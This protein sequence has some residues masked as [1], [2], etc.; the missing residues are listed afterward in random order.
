M[1]PQPPQL[2][3]LLEG[4]VVPGMQGH[5]K[6]VPAVLTQRP[7]QQLVPDAHCE[8]SAQPQAP[9]TQDVPLAQTVP[10]AP[11]CAASFSAVSQ[12]FSV[13]ASQSAKPSSHMPSLQ[14]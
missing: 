6:H 9:L 13:F 1:L 12:P 2:S 14:V 4:S 8:S 7:S 11:Q 3:A 5:G 10:H